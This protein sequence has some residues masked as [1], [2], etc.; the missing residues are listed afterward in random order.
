[1]TG[2]EPLPR[3]AEEISED[4][5]FEALYGAWKPFD[6]GGVREFLDGFDGPWWIIGGWSIDAFTGRPRH[7]EDI[8]V[9]ILS[10]D[11]PTLREH[12]GD[13]W[14]LW[15]A[16]DGALRPVTDRHPDLVSPESQIW[17]RRDAAS[18]WV[19]DIPITPDEDGHW[20]NKR[21]PEQ[22][23]PV[24]QVTWLADDGI[25]YLNPEITLLF[26]AKL[27]RRKDHRDFQTTWPLLSSA[28]QSWL[29]DVVHRL[30]PD[31]DWLE[32]M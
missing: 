26:K 19:V 1:M 2:A 18:P 30:H 21:L 14:H 12:V 20:T 13:R 32:R 5:T 24:E 7:H 31:H 17:V 23:A 6:P 28:Q 15:N 4:E 22:V 11:V 8:D 10:R 25:R 16:F 29:R 9:S 27:G 3:S